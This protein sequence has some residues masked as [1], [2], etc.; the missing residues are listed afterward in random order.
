MLRISAAIAIIIG[1]ALLSSPGRTANANPEPGQ[2]WNQWLGPNRNGQI[3]GPA[4]PEKLSGNY[5][6]KTWRMPLGPSYSSP[7]VSETAVFVTETKGKAIEVVRALDRK[8]G[9]EIWAVEWAGAI[10]V[11]FY[12]KSRGDWIRSTPA[13]DGK[14]LYVAGMRDVLVSLDAKTGKENW[15]ID[16]VKEYKTPVPDFGL[17]SSPLIDGNVLYLQAA[18]AVVKIDKNTGKVLW[19]VFENGATVF[20][21]GAFSSPVIA[22]VAGKRQLI[23]QSREKLAGLD[24]IT[25]DVLWS[26]GVPSFRGM[27][28]MTPVVLG[29]T[30]FTSSYQ[31]KSWLYQISKTPEN[32]GVSELWSNTAQGYMSNPVVID[33]YAYMHLANQRFACIDLKTGERTWTSKPYG[34]YWSIVAQRDRL[35]ALDEQGKLLLIK[36]NP[37]EFQL[38]D[39]L[40]ISE[41]ETWAHVAVCN[42]EIYI[43][44]LNAIAA[45]KWQ[46]PKPNAAGN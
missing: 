32:Y 26:H 1:F 19:R 28:I 44:E 29:D 24:L 15:R 7:I 5:V 6:S 13:Y 41:D 3:G 2:T 18:N 16:F 9:K 35:L 33:G 34:K 30:V 25:G 12:A 14:N 8:T 45:Y 37:R 27:N 11:P 21:S 20:E 43:R 39:E 10:S 46:T 36:A 42:D 23:V 17:V 22:E 4:W 31:N 40:Q 38:I